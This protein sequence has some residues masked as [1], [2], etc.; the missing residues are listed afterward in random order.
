MPQVFQDIQDGTPL[1]TEAAQESLHQD[2]L[3][4]LLDLERVYFRPDQ[5]SPNLSDEISTAYSAITN[6]LS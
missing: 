3:D 1:V 5:Y 2:I 6:N 4:N